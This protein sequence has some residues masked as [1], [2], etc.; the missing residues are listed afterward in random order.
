[1][2]KKKVI[3]DQDKCIG[4]NTCVLLD[5]NTFELDQNTFKALVK[6]QPDSIASQTQSAVDS[7]PVGAIS[8]VDD[9]S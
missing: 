3:V 8:I 7:C 1:M 5:P 6:K 9:N 4:C 2:T